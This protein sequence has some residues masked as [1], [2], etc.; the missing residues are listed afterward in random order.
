M[1]DLRIIVD[2]AKNSMDELRAELDAA[3]KAEFPGGMLKRKWNG[4]LLELSGPGASGSIR[5]EDN[6]II[7]EASLKPP[8]TMMRHKIEEK[9][10]AALHKASQ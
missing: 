3:L 10:S 8:A 9:M 6:R 7:G 4:D 5:Y 2:T 1:S